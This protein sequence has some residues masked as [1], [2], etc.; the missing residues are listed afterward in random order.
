MP[1]FGHGGHLAN[2]SCSSGFAPIAPETKPE[3]RPHFFAGAHRRQESKY[4]EGVG[5]K[6]LK[7]PKE[8]KDEGDK[9][10]A[11]GTMLE[12]ALKLYTDAIAN[13]DAFEAKGE[14]S[15]GLPFEKKYSVHHNRAVCLLEMRKFPEAVEDAEMVI[16]AKP[17]W[18]NGYLRKGSA[19]FAM[20]RF[21]DARRAYQV[22]PD[23]KTSTHRHRRR[24]H[25]RPLFPFIDSHKAVVGR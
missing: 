12:R 13:L 19:L 24:H 3:D 25:R 6:Q 16:A 4:A 1:S 17:E 20:A 7:P 22:G 11:A 5:R 8:L 9:F 23:H 14:K 21:E 2:Q 18:V 10:L 15:E